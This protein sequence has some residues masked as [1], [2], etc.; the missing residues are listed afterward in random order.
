MHETI[1]RLAAVLE[2]QCHPY[3]VC[4]SR[5]LI[6]AQERGCH[7]RPYVVGVNQHQSQSGSNCGGAKGTG[8]TWP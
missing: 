6:A 3:I 7:G 2:R 4:E 8:M 5:G 1:R